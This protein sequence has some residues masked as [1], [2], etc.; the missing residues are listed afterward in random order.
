MCALIAAT[1]LSL[2][3]SIPK[4]RLAVL[5]VALR[6]PMIVSASVVALPLGCLLR[7][8]LVLILALSCCMVHLRLLPRC[9]IAF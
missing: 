1:S 2:P 9:S 8:L 6:A 3:L 4:F 5:L 7:V